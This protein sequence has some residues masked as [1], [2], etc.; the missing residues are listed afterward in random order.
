MDDVSEKEHSLF[1]PNTGD[2]VS[3]DPLGEFVD[4]DK[5]VGEPAS[6]SFQR[7][8]KVEPPN[9]KWPRDGNGLQGMCWK[10][11]LSRIVLTTLTGAH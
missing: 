4:G 10:V 7:S 2:R 8:D 6:C 1:G 11:G 9:G 3:L 5:Q